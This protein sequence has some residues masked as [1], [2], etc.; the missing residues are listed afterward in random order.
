[1]LTSTRSIL[2]INQ[3]FNDLQ[4]NLDY[5]HRTYDDYSASVFSLGMTALSA[6][7]LEDVSTIYDFKNYQILDPKVF[8]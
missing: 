4:N 5:G 2:L 1:M 8:F 7:T 3:I 6:A